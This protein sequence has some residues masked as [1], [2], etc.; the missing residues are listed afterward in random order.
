MHQGLEADPVQRFHLLR[1]QAAGNN[2]GPDPADHRR[3]GAHY[4]LPAAGHAAIQPGSVS[5]LGLAPLDIVE[6]G[7]GILWIIRS[8]AY[9]VTATIF[10]L[11][12]ALGVNHSFRQVTYLLRQPGLMVRSLL[13]VIVMVPGIV[14]VLV[15][16]FSLPP[17]VAT[18]LALLAAAPG[19][20]VT[21]K[22]VEM[23]GGEME[24]GVNLQL[25]LALLAV[26]VTPLTLAVFFSIFDLMIDRV[27]PLDVARQVAQVTFLP[28]IAGFLLRYFLPALADRIGNPLRI[29]GNILLIILLLLVV[30]ALV[31]APDLRMM[32]NLG[33]EATMAI[34]LM[35]ALSLA[36]GHFLGGPAQESGRCWPSPALPA[37]LAWRSSSRG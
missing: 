33:W 3:L 25:T 15:W 35:V 5:W 7:W 13:S 6:A 18:G 14:V 30:V 24:Y 10:S 26:V 21:Y 28:V 32:L 11:M 31:I 16:V 36:S 17:A 22:R 8:S 34:V 29:L 20:P 4:A 1:I 19:A 37:T 23:A 12:F 27:A 9:F 2:R